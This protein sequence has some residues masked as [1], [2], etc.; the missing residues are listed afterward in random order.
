MITS[1]TS[2]QPTNPLPWEIT[3]GP[4]KAVVHPHPH[5]ETTAQKLLF[6]RLIL[7][8]QFPGASSP[9]NHHPDDLI[10]K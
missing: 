1:H 9:F 5:Q 7:N 3:E 6:G 2:C 10:E 4:R 8:T